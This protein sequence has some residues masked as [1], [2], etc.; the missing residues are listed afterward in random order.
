MAITH[1]GQ[2]LISVII[3]CYNVERYL[4]ECVAS[5]C[6][7]S[8]TNIEIL[9]VDDGST[10]STPALCD[11]WA[12]RDSRIRVLHKQNGGQS[13][14]RN[15][16]WEQATGEYLF[17]LDSD[18]YIVETALETLLGIACE[19]GA[20]FVISGFH[21]VSEQG[22]IISTKVFPDA[23]GLHYKEFADGL[24]K[25]TF[26]PSPWGKLFKSSAFSNLRFEKGRLFEDAYFWGDALAAG[27]DVSI[28]STSVIT[29]YYRQTPGSTMR[30]YH[31][32][33]EREMVAV[34]LYVGN[35]AAA[36]FPELRN[37]ADRRLCEAYFDLLDRAC[38]AEGCEAAAVFMEA[39]QWLLAHE[40]LVT[41]PGN[42]SKGRRA[43]YRLLKMSRP[44]YR[45]ARRI[46]NR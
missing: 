31:G 26:V 23:R 3:P 19:S 10:D 32:S 15:A 11:A 43:T 5:V 45:V 28:A 39:A 17:F 1:M 18:D 42:F 33:R 2:A 37:S 13:A 34:W 35:A 30:T 44:L 40:A 25:N 14:A 46:L 9:L 16:A 21:K 41:A 4:D 29:V 24:F 38:M 22:E 27:G 12:Q 6:A 7:Q 8:Y 36:R 20:D